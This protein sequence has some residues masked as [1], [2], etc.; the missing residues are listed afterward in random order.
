MLG[1]ILHSWKRFEKINTLGYGR[2]DRCRHILLWLLYYNVCELT[3]VA[4]EEG[5]RE[6]IIIIARRVDL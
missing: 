4:V 5:A 2:R 1:V 6:S 3:A